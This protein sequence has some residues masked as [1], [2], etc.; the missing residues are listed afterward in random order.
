LSHRL[1]EAMEW[2]PEYS[3]DGS[4]IWMTSVAERWQPV[5]RECEWVMVPT[6]ASLFS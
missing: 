3:D 2:K 4:P 5:G 6:F 1:A